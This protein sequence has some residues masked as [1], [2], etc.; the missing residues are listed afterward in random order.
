MHKL[1]SFF[2]LAGI[3]LVT[4]SAVA[5]SV[6]IAKDKP[7]SVV[8]GT[9]NGNPA[10]VTD[11]IF[12]PEQTQWQT[13]TAWWHGSATLEIAFGQAFT[14]HGATVQCDDNDSYRLDYFDNSDSTWKTLWNV[15]NYNAY[16]WGMLT[17]P[18]VGTIQALTPV[19]TDKVRFTQEQGD[20][21]YSVSEI[22][23]FGATAVPLPASIWGGLALA[24]FAFARRAIRK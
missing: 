18:G 3:A 8:F 11:G 1:I 10:T 20:N 5:D 14:I 7:V 22:Q 21:C 24:G 4:S 17:R 6:N 23:L 2:A 16:G 15:P 19:T 13:G 12:L 9:V